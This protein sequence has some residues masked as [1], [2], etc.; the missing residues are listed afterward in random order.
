MT[1][2]ERAAIIQEIKHYLHELRLIKD[3]T[4]NKKGDAN[5]TKS[6]TANL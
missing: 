3:D 4:G 6:S 5:P 1:A 2:E